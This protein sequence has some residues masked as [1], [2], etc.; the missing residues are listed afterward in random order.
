MP[1]PPDI[2]PSGPRMPPPEARSPPPRMPP[3]DGRSPP[4]RIPP[5]YDRRSLPHP[6]DRASPPLRLPPQEMRGHL[7]PHIRSPPRSDSPRGEIMQS[8]SSTFIYYFSLDLFTKGKFYVC[9]K[10]D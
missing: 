1:P 2:R 7:P 10:L 6:M 5:P 9:Y 8:R 4:P 3:P